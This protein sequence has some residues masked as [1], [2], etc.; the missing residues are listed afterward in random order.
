MAHPPTPSDQ[1][2]R[3]PS[4]ARHLR[5]LR[6]HHPAT[7]LLPPPH[8]RTRLPRP[9]PRRTRQHPRRH[10]LA[11]PHRPRRQLRQDHPAPRRTPP[12]HRHR[13][14]LGQHRGPHAHR[15]PQHPHHRHH[16]RPPHPR[17]HPRHHPQLPTPKTEN[18]PSQQL[19]VFTMTRDLS[20]MSRVITMVGEGGLEPP[21]PEGHWHLKPARLPFR[22][23][24][25]QPEDHT[26]VV[27]ARPSRSGG[28]S[29]A[30][31][32][33]EVSEQFR[34]DSQD[35]HG[36][37][38]SQCPDSMLIDTTRGRVV[39]LAPVKSRTSG[40]SAEKWVARKGLFS[41]SSANSRRP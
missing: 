22:H 3:P 6:Q 29:T 33:A 24:P 8:P 21:R 28:H 17:T 13:P 31:H 30:A 20:S 10:P 5:P 25:E 40:A 35:S 19:K 15:R 23:S 18:T 39:C 41:A 16:Q 2:R 32:R 9:T 36:A 27:A 4:P 37:A 1:P 26:T 14:P 11:S 12:P 34:S 38:S 7:P